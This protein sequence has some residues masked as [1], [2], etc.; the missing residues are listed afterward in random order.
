MKKYLIALLF[1]LSINLYGCSYNSVKL[2][3][4]EVCN[5]IT[6]VRYMNFQGKETVYTDDDTINMMTD[7]LQSAAYELIDDDPD[8]FYD[9]SFISNGKKYEFGYCSNIIKYDWKVYRIHNN[10]FGKLLSLTN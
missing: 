8:G 7:V 9:F 3:S 4:E 10:K 5:G 2:F 6:E 1:L